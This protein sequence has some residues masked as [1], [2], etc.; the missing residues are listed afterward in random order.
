MLMLSQTIKN[1]ELRNNSS[2]IIEPLT[3]NAAILSQLTVEWR[4]EGGTYCIAVYMRNV[5]RALFPFGA[6]CAARRPSV[7]HLK[8]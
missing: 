1:V 8:V 4:V 5:S 3:S 7:F 6:F 2:K